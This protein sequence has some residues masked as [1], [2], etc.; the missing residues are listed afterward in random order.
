MYIITHDIMMMH[1]GDI[2]WASKV[3]WLAEARVHGR[4]AYNAYLQRNHAS[5]GSAS[6][7]MH[8]KLHMGGFSSLYFFGYLTS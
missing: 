5:S 3:V 1:Y 8:T 4:D 2:K 7:T 6:L